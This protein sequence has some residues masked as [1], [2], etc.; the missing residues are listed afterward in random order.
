M[1]LGSSATRQVG[2]TQKLNLKLM[3][4]KKKIKDRQGRQ[5][6]TLGI[7]PGDLGFSLCML[8]Y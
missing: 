5:S 7:R 2:K 8:V 3:A 1:S 4:F 6:G